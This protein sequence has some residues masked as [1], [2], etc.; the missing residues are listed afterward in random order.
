MHIA[1]NIHGFDV[2]R[3]EKSKRQPKI[4]DFISWLAW[5]YFIFRFVHLAFDGNFSPGISRDGSWFHLRE[6]FAMKLTIY[7][8]YYKSKTILR[9]FCSFYTKLIFVFAH[10]LAAH[11]VHAIVTV[12]KRSHCQPSDKKISLFSFCGAISLI[13][14]PLTVAASA[15]AFIVN[16]MWHILWNIA[17]VW[18]EQVQLHVNRMKCVTV[19]GRERLTSVRHQP[20][21]LAIS[22]RFNSH[23][24]RIM[25]REMWFNKQKNETKT[26]RLNIRCQCREGDRDR[27]AHT[28]W[29][30][31]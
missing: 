14:D 4:M 26:I 19:N 21:H 13:F 2:I 29:D 10:S 7:I 1:Q 8:V 28:N 31:E 5:F 24:Q 25:P 16:E 11:W 6:F 9:L 15:T 3:W 20:K 23:W 18:N 27:N 22:L 12:L 17:S 30:W